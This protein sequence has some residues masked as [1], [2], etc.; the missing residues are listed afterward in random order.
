MARCIKLFRNI[1]SVSL[2]LALSESLFS[3]E[4]IPMNFNDGS[5]AESYDGGP[6][7]PFEDI[8]KD[9]C[10]DTTIDNRKY[11][12]LY[13][14]KLVSPYL[15]PHYTTQ[16]ALIGFIRNTPDKK[17]QYIPN[18]E[19]EPITIYNFNLSIGD[20]IKGEYY[21]LEGDRCSIV[22]KVIDSVEISGRYH[23]RY[24]EFGG[25]GYP[26]DPDPCN[27]PSLIEGVGYSVGLLGY[28]LSFQVCG[29]I[30]YYLTYYSEC[31]DQ[32][33][34]CDHCGSLFSD[35]NYLSHPNLKIFPNPFDDHIN[36]RSD[37]T[38]TAIKVYD[39]YGRVVYEVN[40]LIT[41]N[42]I[43]ETGDLAPGLY[44]ITVQFADH[45][46]SSLKMIKN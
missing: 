23:K 5:W 20:T 4:Y 18:G 15:G 30:T 37:L 45:S 25:Q 27:P 14:H 13:E 12:K 7:G 33:S 39:I 35:D 24:S 6:A 41:T 31:S 28:F 3:Q 42:K 43:L 44:F 2:L 9:C 40:S 22:V 21:P 16:R 19:A 38:L 36:I 11:Y 8:Y 17:V 46:I 29:E 34:A 10:G 1:F 32:D 26:Y